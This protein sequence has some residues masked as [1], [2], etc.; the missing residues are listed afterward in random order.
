MSNTRFLLNDCEKERKIIIYEFLNFL[1]PPGSDGKMPGACSLVDHFELTCSDFFLKLSKETKQIS[2]A[3]CSLYKK[4]FTELNS[5]EIS[6]ILSDFKIKN[7]VMFNQL[8]TQILHY[9]YTNIEVLKAI[10]FLSIPPFP[11]GNFVEEGD[12]LLLEQV[13]L[14]GRI[15]R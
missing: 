4:K 10:G 5:A 3:S 8:A 6:S 12:L 11:E 13:F 15:F 1:I 14:K 2:E 7:S 9:Y